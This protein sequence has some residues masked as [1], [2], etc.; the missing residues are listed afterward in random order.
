MTSREY[1]SGLT[2]EKPPVQLIKQV[3]QGE[4]F[5]YTCDRTT[6]TYPYLG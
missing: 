6:I 3:P 5:H 4:I 1:F 2:N